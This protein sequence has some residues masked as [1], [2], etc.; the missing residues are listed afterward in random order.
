MYPG[1]SIIWVTELVDVWLENK[2]VQPRAVYKA[3]AKLNKGTPQVGLR[4]K[5][6]DEAR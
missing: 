3:M 5:S 4:F 1:L 2:V 6:S